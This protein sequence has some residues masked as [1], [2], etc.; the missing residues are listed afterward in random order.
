MIPDDCYKTDS[1]L[2]S[3]RCLLR[4]PFQPCPGCLLASP[5]LR[6]PRLQPSLPSHHCPRYHQRPHVPLARHAPA[7][8]VC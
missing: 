7:P 6:D 8:R 1:S 3:L 5:S 2:L 4:R